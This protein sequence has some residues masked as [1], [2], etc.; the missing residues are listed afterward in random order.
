[1]TTAPTA[2]RVASHPGTGSKQQEL[3]RCLASIKRAMP[4]LHGCMIASTDGLPVAHDFQEQDAERIAAMAGMALSLGRR[5]SERVTLGEFQETV[6]RGDKGYLVAYAAGAQ[7]VLVLSGPSDAN[8]GLMRIE[9]R[10]ASVVI[11]KVLG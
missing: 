10:S 11:T 8:L 1:M 7:A 5:I 6:I 2:A 9:A 4:E 3:A